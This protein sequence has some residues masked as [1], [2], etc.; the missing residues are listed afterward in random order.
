VRCPDD[1]T[2]TIRLAA[3]ATSSGTSRLTNTKWPRWLVPN[4]SSNP[5]DVAACGQAMSPALAISRS[6]A[7]TRAEMRSVKARTD[8]SDARSSC[9]SVTWSPTATPASASAFSALARSRTPVRTVAP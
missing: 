6:S 7:S 9:S 5:S 2:N 1:D 4:W 8:A 3:P